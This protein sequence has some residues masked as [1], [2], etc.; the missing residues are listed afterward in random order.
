[1]VRDFQ[2]QLRE[3]G[4][5]AVDPYATSGMHKDNIV[6]RSSLLSGNINLQIIRRLFSENCRQTGLYR[7]RVFEID[8]LQC[9]VAYT[10]QNY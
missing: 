8:D 9:S 10:F 3:V 2:R 5:T 7:S 6:G 4:L 1:M